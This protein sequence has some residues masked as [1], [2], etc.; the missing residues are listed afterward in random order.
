MFEGKEV[1]LQVL[2]FSASGDKFGIFIEDLRIILEI[3]HIFTVPKAPSFIW[4]VV[5]HRGRIITVIDL[6]LLIGLNKPDYD[7]ASR[8]IVLDSEVLDVG[9]FVSHVFDFCSITKDQLQDVP[10]QSSSEKDERFIRH[11]FEYNNSVVSV[12]D[13]SKVEQHLFDLKL[14]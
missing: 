13:K 8:V 4:G 5:N 3:Q 1:A 9:L 7:D 10:V 6:S 14:S 2:L 12:L 11:I